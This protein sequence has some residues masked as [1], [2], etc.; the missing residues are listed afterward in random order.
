[1]GWY[2]VLGG[3]EKNV[4]KMWAKCGQNSGAWFGWVCHFTALHFLHDFI[5][6][7]FGMA[8]KEAALTMDLV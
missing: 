6:I 2:L 7:T 5:V 4:S 1:V 8:P 3:A